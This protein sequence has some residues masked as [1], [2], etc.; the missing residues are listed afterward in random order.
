MNKILQIALLIY[1]QV[2]VAATT[3]AQPHVV[4]TLQNN[5]R[6]EQILKVLNHP[7][8]KHVLVAA[9]RGA[10]QHSPENS[11]SAIKDAIALGVDFVELD[12]RLSKDGTLVLMHDETIDR[13]T[14]G[15]GAVAKMSLAELKQVNL[16]NN[17]GSVSALK[18]PTLA[19]VFE[20][21]KRGVITHLDL[22]DYSDKTLAAIAKLAKLAGM[23]KQLSFYHQQPAVLA[24]ILPHL[25]DA[26]LMP[27]AE[28]PEQADLLVKNGF[29]MV[30]LRPSYTSAK[31]SE[32]LNKQ[33]SAVWVNALGR[34]DQIAADVDTEA[35]YNAF[36]NAK[37]NIIQTDQPQLLIDYLTSKRQRKLSTDDC[38][39]QEVKHP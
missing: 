21:A 16:L 3:S 10:H 34:P 22:K 15:Q 31:L 24:R 1:L 39:Q 14:N 11:L 17:D 25:P 2:F 28:S 6:V 35:G 12:V 13:T 4:S 20:A 23:D 29:K 19:E 5:C 8:A 30:H 32:K 9:H 33:G 36:A 18:I 27:M 7:S 26:W 37:V 38:M